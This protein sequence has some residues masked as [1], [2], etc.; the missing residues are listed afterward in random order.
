MNYLGGVFAHAWYP[1][2]GRLHFDDAEIWVVGTG[3]AD[4][5]TISAHEF[6][7][8]LGLGHSNING[9]L[10]SPF[11][12]GYTPKAE[13]TADDIAAIQAHYGNVSLRYT[14][15]VEGK[16]ETRMTSNSVIETLKHSLVCKFSKQ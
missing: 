15:N 11:Y 5:Y 12:L 7:H 6:G 14:Y 13:L 16:G 4:I 8:V 3:G 1:P 9:S 10:M 2:D